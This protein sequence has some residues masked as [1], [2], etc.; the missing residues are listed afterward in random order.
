MRQLARAADLVK[1]ATHAAASYTPATAASPADGGGDASADARPT[2]RQ[3]TPSDPG[4]RGSTPPAGAAAGDGSLPMPP[5]I[6]V[7]NPGM[8]REASMEV[9]MDLGSPTSSVSR[10]GDDDASGAGGA[11][12]AGGGGPERSLSG[13]AP[14]E[15]VQVG[16]ADYSAAH[17]PAGSSPGREAAGGAPAAA[18]G[19]GGDAGAG[20]GTKKRSFGQGRFGRGGVM[21][22][23]SAAGHSSSGAAAAAAV[24]AVDG[25]ARAGGAKSALQGPTGL[26]L[27]GKASVDGSAA[28]AEPVNT[29]QGSVILGPPAAL[30]VAVWLRL[31]LLLPLLP[32]VY[33]DKETDA[34]KNLGQQLVPALMQL[35]AS[36]VLQAPAQH[37]QHGQQG[38]HPLLWVLL[39]MARV[40]VRGYDGQAREMGAAATEAAVCAEEAL[41]ERLLNVFVG[42][43]SGACH[44]RMHAC[45]H[46]NLYAQYAYMHPS[47]YNASCHAC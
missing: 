24:S 15:L 33:I 4:R 32:A 25:A 42:M 5:P 30:Q 20:G 8:I 19:A 26:P 1:R 46:L 6:R 38:G 14:S 2:K 17:A 3:R 18:I 13:A 31:T 47:E 44:F 12:A 16:S 7:S 28:A 36:P 45:M 35:L 41:T 34:R 11:H 29:A 39:E 22:L 10:M 27:Q 9:D 37:A 43:V 40:S 21:R 23:G